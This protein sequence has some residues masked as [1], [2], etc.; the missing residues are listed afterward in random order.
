MDS[1]AISKIMTKNVECVSPSQKII[2]VKHIYEKRNFHHHIPVVENDKLVGMVSLIDFMSRINN[3]SL[4][5]SDPV[6]NE[7]SVKDIMSTNP[8]TVNTSSTIEDAAKILARGEF[9]ALVVTDNGKV[10]G[11]V[12]TADVIKF[13]IQPNTEQISIH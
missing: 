6:Y 10:E 4:S 3:A 1:T 2:D 11:I 12:S 8:T 7:L 9:H 13:F 5:D